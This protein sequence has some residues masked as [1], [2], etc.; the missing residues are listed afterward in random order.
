VFGSHHCLRRGT[1]APDSEILR[2]RTWPWIRIHP[3][4]AQ[5]SEPVWSGHLPSWADFITTTS[6]FRFSVHTGTCFCVARKTLVFGRLRPETGFDLHCVADH[7]SL[8]LVPAI[9]FSS[10]LTTASISFNFCTALSGVVRTGRPDASAQKS[11]RRLDGHNQLPK[12]VLGVTFNNGIEVIAKP[13][14]R[15]PIT[16]A[17]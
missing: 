5:F 12:L 10:Q 6:G 2:G 17:A 3:F 13:A 11:W 15:Q 14:D 8:D 7:S 4:L 16:A 1:S 9:G